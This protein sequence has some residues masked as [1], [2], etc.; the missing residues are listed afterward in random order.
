MRTTFIKALLECA[1]ADERIWLLCGDLGYSVLEPFIQ[2]Y[3][4]RF[5]NVG[6]AE[7]NMTGIAG[8][9][10]MTG[11]KVVCYSIG[12]FTTLRC[13][14]QIRN[15]VCYHNG[16]VKVVSVGGGLAYGSQ[17]Y[18]HHAV[19]DLAVMRAL[20]NMTV[21]APGDPVEVDFVTR[22]MMRH[23]GPCYL[24]LGKAGEPKLHAADASFAPGK[25]V[26]MR[27]GKDLLLLS[28]GGM[29]PTALQVADALAAAGVAAAV[30]S[31]PF[32]KPLDTAWLAQQAAR[33]PWIATLEEHSRFGGLADAVGGCLA[34][35]PQPVARLL[36][37]AVP[38]LALKGVGGTQQELL[39]RIGLDA[40]SITAAITQQTGLGSQTL[41]QSKA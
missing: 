34:T 6:V 7:Q 19:E 33:Y 9:L 4:Q 41:R 30:A 13:Y 31:C 17:G 21:L 39:Q 16:D 15:D 2:Q 32:V 28:T 10:A 5:I 25:I 11:R 18:T 1:A 12:N 36:P 37:F 3:P 27:P 40:A 26:A 20:P 29:L 8:G 38:E 14:E 23:D 35:Q 24:R 22:W